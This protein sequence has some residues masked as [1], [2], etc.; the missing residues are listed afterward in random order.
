MKICPYC[1]KQLHDSAVRCLYCK[2]AISDVGE[3]DI[4]AEGRR[5]IRNISIFI[6]IALSLAV[7]IYIKANPSGKYYINRTHK[8]KIWYPKGWD[9]FDLNRYYYIYKGLS[10]ALVPEDSDI[11]LICAFSCSKDFQEL[12]PLITVTVQPVEVDLKDMPAEELIKRIS[13]R[14]K[15]APADQKW[16][17]KEHPSAI[18]I[19]GKKFV[20][21]ATAVAAGDRDWENAYLY[22]IDDEKLYTI[23]LSSKPDTIDM[24]RPALNDIA[25]SIKIWI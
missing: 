13:Q 18:E 6:L 24:Y 22:F 4:R 15:F 2:K 19:R 7:A 1:K 10:S 12:D 3:T 5:K 14:L 23:S 8:V 21:Y 11:R 17:V 20:Y 25:G 16:T 9:V